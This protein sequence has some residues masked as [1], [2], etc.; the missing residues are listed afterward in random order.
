M[1][2]YIII[3][4]CLVVLFILNCFY[5]RGGNFVERKSDIELVSEFL[6]DKIVLAYLHLYYDL[7]EFYFVPIEDL[8][9]YD[10]KKVRVWDEKDLVMGK[11]ED[12]LKRKLIDKKLS[13]Y[14]RGPYLICPIP[15]IISK[16]GD[17]IIRDAT[18]D[19][20]GR[21]YRMFYYTYNDKKNPTDSEK[22]IIGDEEGVFIIIS[23]GPDGILQSCA[24]DKSSKEK[25]I[26]TSP[27]VEKA[28]S[29]N[30]KNFDPFNLNITEPDPYAVISEKK[31]KNLKEKAL[32]NYEIF[33]RKER[34]L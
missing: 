2:K 11:C 13:I 6:S 8:T 21:R 30:F 28:N 4:C 7:P 25:L 14:W 9:K 10:V 12:D 20:W 23:G 31:L 33:F 18:R 22:K 29:L 27:D 26:K 24:S 5:R 34:G 15:G 32:E 3:F 17:H 19:I 16:I 1:K